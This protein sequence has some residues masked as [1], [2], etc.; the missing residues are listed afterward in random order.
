MLLFQAKLDFW[1][2]DKKIYLEFSEL[3]R[4]STTLRVQK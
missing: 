2:Y 3:W 4:K 1:N